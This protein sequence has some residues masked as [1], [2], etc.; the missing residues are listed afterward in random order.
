MAQC[1]RGSARALAGPTTDSLPDPCP[2]RATMPGP[3]KC[4]SREQRKLTVS[5][6]F[7]VAKRSEVPTMKLER[8]LR[9][10]ER[11]VGSPDPVPP[12]PVPAGKAKS[13][14]KRSPY[15][16]ASGPF[17]RK[18]RWSPRR[19][20]K[21]SAKMLLPTTAADDEASAAEV[22]APEA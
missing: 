3:G 4:V 7:R 22:G 6:G 20:Q 1:E 9:K 18:P 19:A 17:S 12:D 21:R 5:F 15:S 11:L 16:G 8:Q 10:D 14:K 2:F 13:K